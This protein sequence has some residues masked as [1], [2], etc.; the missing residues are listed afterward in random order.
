MDRPNIVVILTDQLRRAALGCYGDPNISTPHL[1]RLSREGV[2]FTNACS[3][4][5]ICVPFRFTFMTGEYAH[6]RMVPGI[7]WRM[8]PAERTLAD[9]FNDD[10]YDTCYVGKWHLYGGLGPQFMKR[11]IPREHQGRWQ[12]WRGFE[13]RNRFFDSCYFVDDDPTPHEIDGYQTDGLF[14]VALDWLDGD[15][16]DADAPFACVVSV[17][18]PH[19]PIEA[20]AAYEARWR[21]REIS[22]RPNFMV[23]TGS[24]VACDNS[25]SRKLGSEKYD[26]V[27]ALHRIYY[28][29]V[30]NLDDNVGRLLA[31]LERS[32]E[33]DNT[34]V[35]YLSDHGE[36][37]GSHCLLGK[38]YPHEESSGIPLLVWGPGVGVPGGV[39]RPE[40]T[41]S[42]DLFPTFLGLCG[43][44]PDGNLPGTDLS[45][46]VRDPAA[47]LERPG[48]ML[49]FVAELR[50]GVVFSDGPY[51]GFRSER[52]CYTV[53]GGADGMV[54]W[55]FHDLREDPYQLQDRLHDPALAA[56]V[57]QH[58]RWLRA[59]MIE[60]GDYGF[61]AA[62]H[63]EPA[64][65]EWVVC[66]IGG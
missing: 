2:T 19:P 48:V 10:G 5:P 50:K 64:L 62:A 36:F 52:Y 55:Q 43:L 17:E 49:E 27:V 16:R 59:R 9:A 32:G 4:Y 37:C 30:E 47:T 42:E 45:P 23:D 61:L 39:Q 3:T 56:E 53:R 11:P 31:A 44:V 24:A 38:Q 65:N 8:S 57:A 41:C 63:G 33:A 46:L 22:L 18:A 34:I 13:F 7:E 15:A 21:D 26:D 35:V 25:W 28:A 1:D 20:P 66:S 51:R 54:P 58:H 40:P 14:D 60:T 12:H 6:S 29:M